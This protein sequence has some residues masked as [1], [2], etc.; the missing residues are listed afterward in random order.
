MHQNKDM[1]NLESY[2][3]KGK[4]NRPDIRITIDTKE[5]LELIRKI[6]K[7]FN[8][9]DFFTENIIDFLDQ[10]PKLLKINKNIKQKKLGKE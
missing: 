8:N 7:N 6:A 5:D 10:N 4:L 1:F 9:L 2:E 3:A